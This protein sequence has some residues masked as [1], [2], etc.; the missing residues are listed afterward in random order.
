MT[1]EHTVLNKG[2]LLVLVLL[3]TFPAILFESLN[4]YTVKLS[5]VDHLAS[6]TLIVKEFQKFFVSYHSRAFF[7]G[8]HMSIIKFFHDI[9]ESLFVLLI[10]HIEVHNLLENSS[11][12]GESYALFFLGSWQGL[13]LNIFVL[14]T[15]LVNRFGR[16]LGEF[17]FD[18]G[19]VDHS[20]IE[21]MHFGTVVGDEQLKLFQVGLLF[22]CFFEELFLFLR[23]RLDVGF[24][25]LLLSFS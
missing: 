22:L 13:L 15:G 21:R 25:N 1:N 9:I 6:E 5:I 14:G 7:I 20:Q 18:H 24:D 10:V 4:T 3:E 2:L 17:S 12:F 8:A 11:K 16:E 23:Q 19:E